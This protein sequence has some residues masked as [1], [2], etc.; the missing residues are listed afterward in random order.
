MITTASDWNTAN[1]ALGKQPIYVF[2][3]LPNEAVSSPNPQVWYSTA[4]LPGFGVTGTLPSPITP[5]LKTPQGSTQ[6]IDPV[7][8][9]S[10]IGEMQ[11][12]VVDLD[13]T[14]RTY[15][16]ANVLEGAI[17]TLSVG[18]PG[19]A[20]SSFCLLHTYQIYKILPSRDYTSWLF[21]SRDGQMAGK[22]TVSYNPM[23]GNLLTAAN[24]W[25]VMGTPPE[26]I[27][28]VWL[29][30]LGQPLSTIDWVG[31]TALDSA[32]EGFFPARPLCF[33]ITQPFEAKQWL[34][35]EVFKPMG[36]YPVVLNTGQ[37]SARCARP[38]A[39]GPSPVFTFDGTNTIGL[40]QWERMPIYNEIIYQVDQD[41][42]GGYGNYLTYIEGTS[43][44]QYGCAGQLTIDSGG[45]RTGYGAQAVCEDIADRM[46]ARFAGAPEDLKGGAPVLVLD[47]F[48][49]SLP[50]WVGDYVYVTCG[51]MPNP[52][53]GAL[54]VT[55]RVYEVVDRNANYA[56]G[57]MQYKLLDTGIT[58]APAAQA[59]GLAVIG[60]AV[61]Y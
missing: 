56:A 43:V 30:A 52:F 23:N 50:V 17:C 29:W 12:E 20:W 3:I 18:Y 21:C 48:L 61:I 60:S 46:F 7:N 6:T 34:E 2:S 31:L 58:G 33:V 39:A 55:N 45:L 14:I 32:A 54:G 42:G 22:Q 25:V 38:P 8:G 49:L 16:G 59:I 26:I 35:T 36:M 15:I 28:Q 57:R 51:Q 53:T 44:S 9:S 40:P 11:C 47:A 1:A 27:M 4:V 13:G 24:P 37:Y 10:S 41:A 5:W 19:I